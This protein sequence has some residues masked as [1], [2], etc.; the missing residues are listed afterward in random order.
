MR[1]PIL[2]SNIIILFCC[3]ISVGYAQNRPNVIVILVDDLGFS[4][5]GCY[6]GEIPT[7]NIDALAEQGMKFSNFYNA[8]RCCPSRA[9]LLT[10]IYPHQAGI[11]HMMED[12]GED[13]P[14]YRG[15]LNAQ[16]VT[17]GEM[18]KQAGYFTAM[19]GKW[20][21]GQA[22]GIIPSTRGFDRSLNAPAGGFYYGDHPN[23]KL[24]LDGNSIANNSEQL[25]E[26]WYST[27]L[28]TK[29]GLK[30]IDEAIQAQKPFLLYL[31]H[32]APHFPLQGPEEDI[33]KFR[34]KYKAG[35]KKFREARYQKQ[36]DIGL[37]PANYKLPPMNPLVP[38]WDTLSEVEKDKY[39][40]LMAIYAA[41]VSRLDQSVGDLVKGL[42]EK[43]VFENT[44]ILFL[45]DNGGNPEPSALG[46]YIGKN[47][48]DSKSDI[49][50]G[51]GWAEVNCT[52]FWAYKHHTHEGGIATPG[53][54][55]WPNGIHSKLKGTIQRQS[56]HITDIMATLVDLANVKYPK[57]FQGNS[58][59]P[60]VGV[61][62]LPALAGK[63]V[64]RK[65]PIYWEHEG[66][67]AIIQ[68]DWKLV[69]EHTEDWQ[70]YNLANDRTELH[71]VNAQ[72]PEKVAELTSLYT[73]WFAKIK[74]EPW[75]RQVKWF[76]N[77]EKVKNESK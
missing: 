11:G 63:K 69:A 42:K 2:I 5:L 18:M 59:T 52:P 65:E 56:A 74:A 33:A 75:N 29:F 67:K 14:A 41:V 16:N 19:T 15:H 30:F 64:K 28:W 60:Y 49:F 44:L 9:A 77:Y 72:F 70:L 24:F 27:D 66:N 36:L 34:G 48:G 43:G 37:F 17:I 47:P 21:V 22:K 6:G 32:N 76:Y 40:H 53:I 35:W 7:P 31:A 57:Q 68:G 38:D 10:G 61:S 20:H 62:L 45:S 23:A 8:A 55:S 71:N 3:L 26:N 12:K 39:D 51:Q 73:A 13:H 4:D 1:K 54:I 58:I 50:L 46:K 25:P